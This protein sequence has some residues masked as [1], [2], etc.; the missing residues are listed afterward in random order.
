VI[1]NVTVDDADWR[2]RI[3]FLVELY[4]RKAYLASLAGAEEVRSITRR[5]LTALH[6]GP[7]T[8][9][10][11]VA[12]QP[13]AAISGRLAAS[14]DVTGEASTLS[15]LVGPTSFAS[16]RNGPYPRI[17]ELGGGSSGHP[18]MTWVE[19]GV[20]HK[21]RFRRLPERPYLKPATEE[22]VKSGKLRSIYV[23]KWAEAQREAAA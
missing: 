12:G 8:K 17:Q 2:D 9:T 6:H 3:D 19:D 20:F 7:K 21:V 15:A 14:V 10:P 11:S 4:K 18:F 22:I 23:D 1:I 13:P 5:K 16:S